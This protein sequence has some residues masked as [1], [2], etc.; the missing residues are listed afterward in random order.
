MDLREAEKRIWQDPVVQRV[1]QEASRRGVKVYL[2]GGAVRDH[3]LGRPHKDYDFV[4]E[5]VCPSFLK[6]LGAFFETRYFPLGKGERVYRIVKGDKV[7][8]FSP[9]VGADI[10][11]DLRR[12]D[13]TIN[14]IAYCPQER[15]FYSHPRSLEDLRRR[16]IIPLSPKALDDDPL[17]ILRGFRYMATLGFEMAEG[18]WGLLREKGPSLLRVAPERI[19]M[20]MDEILLAPGTRRALE[21][22]GETG[23]LEVLFPELSPLRGV[24]HGRSHEDVF[25]HTLR[26]CCIALEKA[27]GQVLPLGL[28]PGEEEVLVLGYAALWHDLGKGET[29]TLDGEGKVH[30]YGHE[31]LSEEK[32]RCIMERYPFSNERK[33]RVL[34]LVANHMRPLSLLRTGATERALRRLS[35]IMAE[36]LPLLLTLTLAEGEEK[37]EDPSP[38]LDLVRRLSEVRERERAAWESPLIKGKDLLEMG[39]EPGPLV[40]EILRRVREL[41]VEGKLRTKE[42]ALEFV[43][44]VYQIKGRRR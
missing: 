5:K 26:V 22:M 15:K 13:F 31:S 44:Q 28:S 24:L 41:Q 14:A 6:A 11:E 33:R 19:L 12:R 40:G 27:K 42:E 34:R 20:E 29:M 10:I 4:L 32:A 9:M 16:L 7:L 8:D 37:G 3:I 21:A 36:D 30:F 2:V 1:I 39:L 23:V 43:E 17:R 18:L 35:S 25:H 38:L